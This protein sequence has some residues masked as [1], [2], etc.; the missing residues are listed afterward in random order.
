M[1]AVASCALDHYHKVLGKHGKP[2]LNENE[3][4]VYAAIVCENVQTTDLWVVSCGT[5]TKCTTQGPE[6]WCLRDL[7]AEVLAKRGL[8]RV[9]WKEI[10]KTL[11]VA[12][13]TTTT[14]ATDADKADKSNPKGLLERQEGKVSSAGILF[15]LR[16]CLKL[17][18]YI[19][20][21]P[22]GDASIY[23]LQNKNGE[24]KFTGSKLL[25]SSATA[26]TTTA[27]TTATSSSSDHGGVFQILQAGNDGSVVGRESIQALGKL[28]T[29]SGRSN[30]PSHLRSSSMSCS[31]KILRWT[32]LG[33]Q[34]SVLTCRI[35]MPIRLMS[36]VVSSS[37]D[38]VAA[39]ECTTV[40]QSAL[41][42][43]IVERFQ[44]T[45]QTLQSS[46]ELIAEPLLSDLQK[47]PPTVH[48]VSAPLFVVS[49]CSVC[50][51]PFA[52][53][54]KRS[55]TVAAKS[56]SSALSMSPPPSKKQ[57]R[58]QG[59]KGPSS[60]GFSIAWQQDSHN[61][62]ESTEILIGA[63]GI[64][65][66]KKPKS[67]EDYTKLASRLCRRRLYELAM[68]TTTAQKEG[69]DQA[70]SN[71]PN[72]QL[73]YRQWKEQTANPTMQQFRRVVLSTGPLQG[74][75]EPRRGRQDFVL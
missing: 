14:T 73:S 59:P 69:N 2:R 31:D 23:P 32:I 45:V 51:P 24:M 71:Q 75:L 37:S 54:E 44:T 55:S 12:A 66:G 20:E 70:L 65:Q 30:L 8:Q 64:R 35:P 63:R 15:Q 61:G 16:K 40:Q 25:L 47:H 68:E 9:L 62:C 72:T 27:T 10:Q 67:N 33:L 58:Q 57:R 29:K 42:R 41:H 38:T 21:S 50:Q 39:T 28:R 48:V 3:W 4:T 26:A 60:C 52:S 13:T 34:G 17:H 46:N 36:V 5:G 53:E 1:S 22:C 18:L 43:A 6:G 7:H 56:L 74:W 19:S 49:G 11:G